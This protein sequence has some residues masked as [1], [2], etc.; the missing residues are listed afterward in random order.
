[1]TGKL[2]GGRPLFNGRTVLSAILRRVTGDGDDIA[3]QTF[4]RAVEAGDADR[5]ARLA[6]LFWSGQ[7]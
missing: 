1:M 6:A 4:R 3:Y 7:P 5:A 2:R